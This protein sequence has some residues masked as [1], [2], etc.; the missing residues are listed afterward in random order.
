MPWLVLN[1]TY[2][3]FSPLH[4]T[5]RTD[6]VSRSAGVAWITR[7]GHCWPNKKRIYLHPA[8]SVHEDP[9]VPARDFADLHWLFAAFRTRQ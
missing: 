8:Q 6:W 2:S 7:C 3:Y 9:F 1:H 5:P 4:R